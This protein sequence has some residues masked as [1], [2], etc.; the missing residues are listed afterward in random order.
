M[1]VSVDFQSLSLQDALDLAILVEDEAKQ[2][3]EELADQLEGH[4]TPEAADFFRFMIGNEAK[5]ADD[6]RARRKRL[7]AAAPS[8]V[9]ASMI[10]DVEAP[11]YEEVRAF[12]TPREAL[13]VALRA[14]EKAWSFFD[15]AVKALPPGEV[16]TLLT[17]LRDEEHEHQNLVRAQLSRLPEDSAEHPSEYAD[18]PVG[19]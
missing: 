3:Y 2:R 7:F 12:M 6:L 5:H 14:E 9:N 15:D 4:A 19:Q 18:E 13:M 11:G 17:E 1:P 16:A 10:F 8:K